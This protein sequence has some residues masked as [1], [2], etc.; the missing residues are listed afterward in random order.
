M[1]F[2][3]HQLQE[4]FVTDKR[5]NKWS[6]PLIWMK[7][8]YNQLFIMKYLHII[9][10]QFYIFLFSTISALEATSILTF[11]TSSRTT[12]ACW[13][14]TC[15]SLTSSLVNR[16]SSLDT[17]HSVSH[18]SSLSDFKS[19]SRLIFVTGLA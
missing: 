6:Q 16:S 4:F 15:T 10:S 8:K 11:P 7:H 17:R 13:G 2:D 3:P 14:S 1:Y 18:S 19:Q 5:T 9:K 12:S